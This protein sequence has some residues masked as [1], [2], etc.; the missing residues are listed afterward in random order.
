MGHYISNPSLRLRGLGPKVGYLSRRFGAWWEGHEFDPALERRAVLLGSR[1][2]GRLTAASEQAHFVSEALWGPGRLGPGSPSWTMFLA[3]T[4]MIEARARVGVFGAERGGA[5]YD[6]QA[7]TQW[8]VSGYTQTVVS[9]PQIRLHNYSST[10]RKQSKASLDGALMLFEL[11]KEPEMK[12]VLDTMSDM[13]RPGAKAVIVDFTSLRKDVRL[14]KAFS[15]QWP[16][17]LRQAYDLEKAAEQAGMEVSS[18]SNDAKIY[19]PLIGRGWA[20]WRYAWQILSDIRDNRQRSLMLNLLTDYA[21]LW[22]E[23]YD[24]MRSGQLQVTRL[25]VQKPH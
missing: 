23:R 10:R 20:G 11:H 7:G 14:K 4:L 13:L 25:M 1:G 21:S 15:N 24:A 6:L 3:R 9:M 19:L 22:A 12:P 8:N 16:G 2:A 17:T 5:L 18:I